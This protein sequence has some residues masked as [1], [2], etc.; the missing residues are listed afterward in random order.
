LVFKRHV[1]IDLHIHT[2]ASDGSYSPFEI[3][4]FAQERRLGAISITDH[5]TIEGVRAAVSAN[6]T[7]AVQFLA[8]V[9]I[10]AEPPPDFDLSDSL[11]I[12]GYGISIE[13]SE[14]TSLLQRL[15]E[16]RDDRTPLI[17]ERL[18]QLGMDLTYAEL[19]DS[20]SGPQ[21]GR[22]HIAQLMVR[23]GYADSIDDAF[24]HY[25]GR[26]NPAYVDK[27]R[28]PC[29]RAIETIC[30]AGGVAVLAHP[31]LYKLPND[32]LESLLKMLKKMGLQGIEIYYPEHSAVQ[33]ACYETLAERFALLTTGGTDFHGDATP[34]IQIGAGRG[35]FH[36]PYALYEIL[37]KALQ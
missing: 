10:T 26:G 6:M 29:K 12:L 18:Q 36:V 27:F 33:T 3:F 20:F 11:H 34:G 1:D 17:I 2:N 28:V 23:K 9:E 4:T 31:G 16:A 5:D 37:L 15:Q 30:H 24:D 7:S 14:L 21:L 19:A 25:L 22:P 35:D 13:D 8:G 32:R